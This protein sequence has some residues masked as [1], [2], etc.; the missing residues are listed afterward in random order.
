[1]D[2]AQ[3]KTVTRPFY[4]LRKSRSRHL[5]AS[6]GRAGRWETRALIPRNCASAFMCHYEPPA[7]RRKLSG[8]AQ[9]ARTYACAEST[10][11]RAYAGTQ[12]K[13]LLPAR[14]SS[15]CNSEERAYAG[16]CVKGTEAAGS[17]VR[18]G[19]LKRDEMKR[20]RE[21]LC[22]CTSPAV[23]PPRR[24]FHYPHSRREFR[25]PRSPPPCPEGSKRLL[26]SPSR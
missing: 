21:I 24:F 20:A 1:M 8:L 15:S 16:N 18:D 7:L 6:T 26:P 23:P 9:P 2:I 11:A 22:T 19:S 13:A 17:A 12:G 5:K 25:N 4:S 10:D 14:S 3:D